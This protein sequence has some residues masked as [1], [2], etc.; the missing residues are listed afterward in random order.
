MNVMGNFKGLEILLVNKGISHDDAARL[1]AYAFRL[2]GEKVLEI[3]KEIAKLHGVVQTLESICR[4]GA[5]V[6]PAAGG[7]A[8]VAMLRQA[9]AQL[10]GWTI[11]LVESDYDLLCRAEDPTVAA[12][13]FSDL[14]S[15]LHKLRLDRQITRQPVPGKGR[16]SV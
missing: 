16:V 4:Q 6:K 3:R 14:A 2:I 11:S 8:D 13:K 10:H 15:Q 9:V 1:R 12:G 7:A 5:Q